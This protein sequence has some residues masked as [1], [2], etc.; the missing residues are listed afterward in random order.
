MGLTGKES[1][2]TLTLTRDKKKKKKQPKFRLQKKQNYISSLASITVRLFLCVYVC[3]CFAV[4]IVPQPPQCTRAAQWPRD[5]R[6]RSGGAKR[7]RHGT[8][9]R[10]SFNSSLPQSIFLWCSVI[11]LPSAHFFIC[12]QSVGCSV[13]LFSSIWRFLTLCSEM[14][15]F[16]SFLLTMST[17]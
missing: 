6:A 1:Y 15:Y 13:S 12:P 11:N 4:Y 9:C 7:G 8:N 10:H 16:I 17:A 3:A 14:I 2:R 5:L